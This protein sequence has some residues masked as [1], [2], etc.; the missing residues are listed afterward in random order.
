MT[1]L[2]GRPRDAF[3]VEIEVADSRSFFVEARDRLD[4]LAVQASND[5]RRLSRR[6]LAFEGHAVAS[7]PNEDTLGVLFILVIQDWSYRES[8]IPGLVR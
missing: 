1:D 7:E 2:P 8:V 5:E 4:D 3:S 6:E